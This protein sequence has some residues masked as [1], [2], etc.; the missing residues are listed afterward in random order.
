MFVVAGGS[1]GGPFVAACGARIPPSRLLGLFMTGCCGAFDAVLP[2]DPTHKDGFD[3][4]RKIPLKIA[5]MI[6]LHQNDQNKLRGMLKMD[7]MVMGCL[8]PHTVAADKILAAFKACPIDGESLV[9]NRP[10]LA[11]LLATAEESP[12][13]GL[14]GVMHEFKFYV[15][16]SQWGFT[17]ADVG[18]GAAQTTE[19]GG[20]VRLLIANGTVDV[21]VPLS[22]AN[23]YHSGVDGSKLLLLE[24][25]GHVS[26]W[27]DDPDFFLRCIQ[28]VMTDAAYADVPQ[29]DRAGVMT[30][31]SEGAVQA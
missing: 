9:R 15:D 25:E 23:W 27:A 1:G 12:R 18:K 14:D 4:A 5:S 30:F 11:S 17:L 2:T 10:A 28:C 13:S 16:Y 24:G 3:E 7:A 20:H 19:N 31:A 8:N 29:W 21:Q 6:D 22:H 26:W